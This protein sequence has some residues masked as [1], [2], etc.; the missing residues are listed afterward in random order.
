MLENTFFQLLGNY[1]DDD[2]YIKECWI[3][4]HSNY[5]S[6]SRHYHNLSHISSMLSE[7]ETVGHLVNDF[8]CLQFAIFYHDIIYTSHKSD[9]ELQ[10]AL[11][12]E[13][14]IA[15][16][17]F[18]GIGKCFKQIEA[19]KKHLQSEDG[20]TN[21]LLDLDL[22]ILGSDP[23]DNWVYASNIRKEYSLFPDFV[24]NRGRKKVLKAM[25]DMPQVYATTYFSKAYEAKAKSNLLSELKRLE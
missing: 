4:L 13:N 15:K 16:T 7:L 12:F 21:V 20:D 6:S 23:S 18:K 2:D 5:S 22:A 24:Y 11:L 10:S 8:D 17:S 9:N 1:S 25:L 3:E 19:T 14:R